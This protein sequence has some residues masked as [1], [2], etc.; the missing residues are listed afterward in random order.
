MDSPVAMDQEEEN[1]RR[2]TAPNLNGQN[3][4]LSTASS[5][6]SQVPAILESLGLTP[7]EIKLL[8]KRRER[9]AASKEKAKETRVLTGIRADYPTLSDAWSYELAF[10]TTASIASRMR[11]FLWK[12]LLWQ[13]RVKAAIEK[14]AT[15]KWKRNPRWLALLYAKEISFLFGHFGAMRQKM[16]DRHVWHLM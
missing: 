10:N 7:D 1:L 2:K 11:T 3:R 5:Q 6:P 4:A 12:K 15:K 9:Q 14:E 8:T 13:L 16:N